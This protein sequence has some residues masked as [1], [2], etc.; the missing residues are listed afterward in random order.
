[1]QRIITEGHTGYYAK[2]PENTLV[3]FQAVVEFG[4]DAIEFDVWLSR[5]KV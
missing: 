5:A 1:M 2:Y 4:V 3:L